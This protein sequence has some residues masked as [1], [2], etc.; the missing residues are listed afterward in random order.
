MK[1]WADGW[2]NTFSGLDNTPMYGNN[3]EILMAS[4]KEATVINP[5]KR[6]KY[7]FLLGVRFLQTLLKLFFIEGLDMQFNIFF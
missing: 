1:N 5:N 7:T 2:L 4:M 3:A 6:I